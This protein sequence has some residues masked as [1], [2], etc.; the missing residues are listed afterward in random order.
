MNTT[1]K[2]KKKDSQIYYKTKKYLEKKKDSEINQKL[3]LISKILE[4]EDLEERY[5]YLYD[6]ICD[7]LD[8]EFQKKN[9]CGFDCG[10][11]K[12]RRDMIDK[13]IVKDTYL[14]G[15]CHGYKEGRDCQYLESGKGCRIKNIA[16]KTY[17]CFYLRRR[18]YRYRLKDIYLA[19]YF[20]NHRQKFY[21]ENT[22]FV[23]KPVII[24]GIMK[25]GE[26]K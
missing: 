14:N 18:G 6:L 11:C 22:Y 12:K 2:R 26:C 7:Y 16:C 21:I 23:D 17:T 9:I 25:R 1:V 8:C 24:A 10:L 5:R 19:R 13:N 3:E 4:I 15:C 20:F